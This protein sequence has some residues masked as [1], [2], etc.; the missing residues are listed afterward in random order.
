M[1]PST[2]IRSSMTPTQANAFRQARSSSVKDEEQVVNVREG[3]YPPSRAGK[4]GRSQSNASIF[5]P[6]TASLANS[7]A[8]PGSFSSDLKIINSGR[9]TASRPDISPYPSREDIR[10]EETTASE[11]RQAEFK[12][13]I[14]KETKIKVGSENLLE[15]LLAKNAKQTKDQRQKVES[16]L[17]TSNRRIAEWKLQLEEEIE[18]SKRPTTPG[19]SRLSSIFRGSPLKS[20]YQI[21]ST[22]DVDR[23]EVQGALDAESPT[24]A[25]T[26]ILEALEEEGMQPDHYVS[27]ANRLAEL[28]KRH[29]TLKYDLAW[30]IFGL[31]IQTMLL[32][33]SRDVVA[34]GFRVLRYA[35]SDRKSLQTI[36]ALHTDSLVILSLV[37]ESKATIEREQALKFVRAFLDVKEGSEEL[38]NAVVRT[39]VS[40]AEHHELVADHHEDR[41]RSIAILTLAEIMVKDAALVVTAGGLA[42]LTHA[43]GDGSYPGCESL[44][45]V[46]LLMNDTPR[47]RRLLSSGRELE[48]PFAPFTDPLAIHSHEDRLKTNAR[49]VATIINAWPGLFSLAKRGFVTVR[50]LLSSLLH[51]SPFAR[52]LML[53]LLFDVLHIK[54]PAWTSSFLAGR[55]LTTYG[56]VINLRANST[57]PQSQ[58]ESED[59]VNRVNLI[60]HYTAL[61]LAVLIECGLFQV[62][63]VT[64]MSI[65]GSDFTVGVVEPNTG[66]L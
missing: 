61:I 11:K 22:P 45:S 3:L 57:I 9:S 10:S 12:D 41:L 1:T 8:Q 34:A 31:R 25:L 20:P 2:S 63:A 30:S 54:P 21:E 65:S 18:R 46:F 36:R 49:S 40:I 43:L 33:E 51:P 19:Q 52:D 28:F 35:M 39:L 32:S 27:R 29:P 58:L 55:R 15:A 6:R 64:S 23:H 48:A 50:S 37:K 16:E 44:V 14:K 59:D 47:L 24:Y 53:D 62:I 42:P 56:R 13:K 60:D 17:S 66:S 5:G 4:D 7:G 38:S 26:E